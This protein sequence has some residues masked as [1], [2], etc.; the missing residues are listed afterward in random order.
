[1]KRCVLFLTILCISYLT[2]GLHT[3]ANAQSFTIVD[4]IDN[5]INQVDIRGFYRGVAWA[6]IDGDGDLD[7]SM[8]GFAF[9]NEGNDQFSIIESFGTA[10]TD[11][12][13]GVS[14]ADYGNDGDLDCLYSV[15]SGVNGVIT[16]RTFIYENDGSGQFTEQLIDPDPDRSLKTWSASWGEFNNDGYVDVTGA[17]AFGFLSGSLDTPGYFYTG[18]EDGTFTEITDAEFTEQTAPYTVAYWTDYDEDGDSD[19]FIASGP[20]GSPGPDFHYK[21]MLKENGIAELVRITGTPFATD[22]QDGQ[23]YNFI[24]HDLDGDLDLCLTNYGGAPNRFYENDNGTYTSVQN[25]LTFAAPALGNCWGDFDNDGDQDVLITAD[26][27]SLAGYFRNDAGTFEKME[28]PFSDHFPSGTSNVSGLSIGDYDNDGDLDFF[29]NG[30]ISNNSGPRALYR[31]DLNNDNHWVNFHLEGN[32]SN[33]AAIGTR[34]RVKANID[35]QVLW[36]QREITAQNTFMGHNSLRAHFGLGN[37]VLVD[38]LI[39]EW[40]SGNLEAYVNLAVDSFYQVVEGQPLVSTEDV[41]TSSPKRQ[42]RI[43]PNPDS[44]GSINIQN[45][46]I[47]PQKGKLSVLSANGSVLIA[48]QVDL[49]NEWIPVD[50]SALSSGV[51]LIQLRSNNELATGKLVVH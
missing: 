20:G 27:I 23:N 21:N 31:N 13:G 12:L 14:W 1:M 30:G 17:V 47:G 24:D 4:D 36:L 33:R 8:Q 25:A 32:P 35:G 39:L 40:P 6:D 19:L 11:F 43:S 16:P 37:A 5:P 49:S 7:L 48:S 42:L 38:S 26:N 50:T 18:D 3:E 22:N 15:A 44:S 41:F 51:Y 2:I 10:G 29:A 9:R 46:F 45:T 28:N 34:L